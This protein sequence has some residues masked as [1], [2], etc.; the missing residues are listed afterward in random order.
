MLLCHGPD[1]RAFFE[2]KG[3]NRKAEY[4]VDRNLALY[5]RD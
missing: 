1:A 4:R 2:G 3:E 5:L